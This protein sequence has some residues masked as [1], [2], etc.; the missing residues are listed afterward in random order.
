MG[1]IDIG[2]T[3]I[4]LKDIVSFLMEILRSTSAK[5]TKK[6]WNREKTAGTTFIQVTWSAKM[7]SKT[8]AHFRAD[9]YVFMFIT[10]IKIKTDYSLGRKYNV[11]FCRDAAI[12]TSQMRTI[13]FL[14][15]ATKWKRI[16]GNIFFAFDYVQMRK[17]YFLLFVFISFYSFSFRS[18]RSHFILLYIY[19]K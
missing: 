4:K 12:A 10:L 11:E 9:R 5:R 6:P 7:A 19:A 2:G 16:A 8:M 13:Y 17:I 1:L 3:N 18:I 15:F 14:P